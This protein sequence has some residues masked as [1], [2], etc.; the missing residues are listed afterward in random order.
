MSE[1]KTSVHH[2]RRD[3]Q[4]LRTDKVDHLKSMINSGRYDVSEKFEKII[5]T[6]VREFVR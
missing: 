5:D 3:G 2:P 6:F 1:R 4:M